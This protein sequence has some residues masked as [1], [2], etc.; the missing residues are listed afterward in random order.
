MLSFL[1]LGSRAE[2]SL[3]VFREPTEVLGKWPQVSIRYFVH[4]V[5]QTSADSPCDPLLSCLA[6][7]LGDSPQGNMISVSWPRDKCQSG[8]WPQIH[9]PHTTPQRGNTH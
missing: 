1:L 2:L 9:V 5:G 6:L 8:M 7:G 3:L 4:S